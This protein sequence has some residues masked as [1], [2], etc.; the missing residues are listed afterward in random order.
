MDLTHEEEKEDTL[1]DQREEVGMSNEDVFSNN[2]LKLMRVRTINEE[3]EQINEQKM[4][5]VG[6]KVMKREA[7]FNMVNRKKG[8]QFLSPPSHIKDVQRIDYENNS[9]IEDL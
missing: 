9:V 6:Q 5:K 4:F 7:T 1:N 8:E 2:D 3:D